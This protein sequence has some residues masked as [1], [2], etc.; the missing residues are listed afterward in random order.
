TLNSSAK[1]LLNEMFHL[2]GAMDTVVN[3]KFP[4]KNLGCVAGCIFAFQSE[5]EKNYNELSQRIQICCKFNFPGEYLVGLL[6]EEEFR[7]ENGFWI[8]DFP[9]CLISSFIWVS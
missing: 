8:E 9:A 4:I 1:H 7:R 6:D 2:N 5:K 3:G